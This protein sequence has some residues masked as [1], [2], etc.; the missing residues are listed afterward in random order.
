[1]F[2]R[3]SKEDN[4]L[5]VLSLTN[6]ILVP[7]IIFGIIISQAVTLT[8]TGMILKQEK[9]Q[10]N[11][12]LLL[13][14]IILVTL[15]ILRLELYMFRLSSLFMSL[16]YVIYDIIVLLYSNNIITSA[17]YLFISSI[18]LFSGILSCL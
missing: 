2:C 4:S 13:P 15:D 12:Y 14:L 17:I 16:G 10:S 8:I 1:M 18:Q 6:E 3:R 11:I 5:T 9:E 7:F